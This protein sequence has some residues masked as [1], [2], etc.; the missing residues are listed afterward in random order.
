MSDEGSSYKPYACFG[1]LKTITI[2]GSHF[3][4]HALMT[5]CS[6]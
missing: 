5:E 4:Q 2:L 6:H 1:Q 3:W